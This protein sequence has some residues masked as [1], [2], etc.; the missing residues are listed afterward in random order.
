MCFTLFV[1]LGFSVRQNL[2]R[3]CVFIDYIGPDVLCDPKNFRI[4]CSG[5]KKIK[6][7]SFHLPHIFRNLALDDNLLIKLISWFGLI[8][9]L[10]YLVSE[11]DKFSKINKFSNVKVLG[12]GWK[13]S[14]TSREVFIATCYSSFGFYLFNY[15]QMAMALLNL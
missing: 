6:I 8:D 9:T 15:W 2:V 14:S 10:S 4:D 11:E 1:T 13:N 12:S 5:N 3:S 7:K